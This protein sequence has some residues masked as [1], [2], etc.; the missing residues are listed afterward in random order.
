MTL[1]DPL[2]RIEVTA[3]PEEQVRQW[4]INELVQTFK[5]PVTLMMSEVGFKFGGK[6]YR[7]DILIYDRAGE[8]LCVV[9]CKRPEVKL[10]ASVIEQA[11]RYNAVLSVRFIILTNGNI[12]YLYRRKGDRFEPMDH[13][14][15]YEQMLCRQ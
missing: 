15:D 11:M 12:T 13:I 3:T 10:T 8:P 2:R 14:P 7:A 5:V 4:F 1:R 6:Q 9:E